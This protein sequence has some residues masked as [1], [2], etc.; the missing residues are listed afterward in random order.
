[1]RGKAEPEK[2]RHFFREKTM[3]EK[4]PIYVTLGRRREL[5]MNLNTEIVIKTAG[6]TRGLFD[7]IGKRVNEEG[8][9]EP[10]LEVNAENLRI[11]LW[12]MILPDAKAH[13]EKLT[14]EDVG[15][16]ITRK[17]LAAEAVAAVS[18]ALARYL[19]DD[20]VGETNAPVSA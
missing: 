15:A 19:G 16:L 11:Y 7:T 9:E 8:E 13:G 4:M 5:T 10:I 6:G 12:A 20:P 2:L 18:L 3:I 14:V 17:R 1:M